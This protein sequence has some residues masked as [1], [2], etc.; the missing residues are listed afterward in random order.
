MPGNPGCSV[1]TCPPAACESA[2]SSAAEESLPGLKDPNIQRVL[3]EDK[4]KIS[5][6]GD[7]RKQLEEQL[8]K[9]QESC[10]PPSTGGGGSTKKPKKKHAKRQETGIR[11]P[12]GETLARKVR[13][14]GLSTPKDHMAAFDPKRTS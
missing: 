12:F 2:K 8:A 9:C 3:N 6:L 11:E 5:D 1:A 14:R 4:Q 10:K 7:K 13:Y